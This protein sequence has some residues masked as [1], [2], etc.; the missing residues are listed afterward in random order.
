MWVYAIAPT[1]YEYMSLHDNCASAEPIHTHDYTEEERHIA[2]AITTSLL[3]MG[4]G[5]PIWLILKANK[6]TGELTCGM[7]SSLPP[8][9]VA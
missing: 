8:G 4:L 9:F 7:R 5:N 1:T 3:G 6:T 2:V